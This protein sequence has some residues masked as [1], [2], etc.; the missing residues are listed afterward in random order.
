M[1][2]IQKK[3]V[4]IRKLN[5]Y[6]ATLP[7]LSEVFSQKDWVFYGE[8][9]VYPNFLI[10][11]YNNCA[12]HK[13]I[14][15]SK[16]SQI[17]GDGLSCKNN[18]MATVHLVNRNEN[19]E[20]VYKKCALD[21][22]LFGGFSLNVVWKRDRNEGIAEIHHLD[23][24][25]VRCGKIEDIEESDE[26]DRYYYSPDWGNTRKY[27]PTEYPAFDR[28]SSD[29][30]QILYVKSYQPSNDYYPSP[31]YSGALAAI[32]ISIEI[33]NF[34][35]NNLKNGMMPT[36]FIGFN[37]GVPGPEEQTIITRALEESYS[38]SDNAGRAVISFNESKETAP[39][40]ESIAPNGSDN[41]YT[42]IYEDIIRS[43]LSGHRVSSGELFGISTAGKLG[44]ANEILEHSEFFRNTV[45]KAYIK[46]LLPTFNKL[47]SLKFQ[48]PI[49]LK[50]DPLT[51]LD[52]ANISVVDEIKQ[53]T[54][55]AEVKQ[56]IL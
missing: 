49:I 12:I 14:V 5:F 53:P 45:V 56:E 22:V 47:M 25:R 40:V 52:V 9:N 50:V 46:E 6:N 35:K 31:D 18:P 32:D 26:V 27:K 23:F 19:I 43:I 28:E 11:Q 33:Q 36:L 2:E 4:N 17:V 34:H 51:I 13:A 20:E 1:E 54:E 30:S 41:Y 39:T 10:G 24:S 3:K 29:P 8:N 37:N 48:E 15:Q 16:V 7:V 44:S 42:T 38:G 55:V 21:L